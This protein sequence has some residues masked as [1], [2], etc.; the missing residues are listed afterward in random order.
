MVIV[1]ESPAHRDLL[2]ASDS[3]YSPW[4]STGRF[5][6]PLLLLGPQ[7]Y[8][9]IQRPTM[10][11]K[12]VATQLCRWFFALPLLVIRRCFPTSH[13]HDSQPQKLLTPTFILAWLVNF[14]QFLTFYVLIT[15]MALYAI[16]QFRASETMGGL[17]S[18]SFIIGATVARC[19]AGFV[20]DKVGKRKTLL[21]SLAVIVV[22]S[23]AYLLATSLGPLLAVRLI[24]GVGYAFA[25]TAV[26][27][28]AQ[29]AIPPHRRAEGTGYFALGPTLSTAAGPAL[30]VALSASFGYTAMFVTSACFA[31][32]G[33][34]IA[35][36]L[37]FPPEHQP[38]KTRFSLATIVHP[39]VIP[40]GCF[41][42]LIG[43]AY[44][45]VITYLN[46][47]AAHSGLQTG[48]SFFFIA[49]AAAMLIMRFFLGRL[50]DR[51]GDNVVIAL[52]VVSFI[53]AL[54]F[55]ATANATWHVIVAGAFTG[56][57][58]GTLMPACQ[59]I[60]VRLVPLQQIGVGIS[61]MF[62]LLDFGVGFG[63][64]VL[65]LVATS[66]GYSTMYM[67]MAG[68]VAMSGVVYILVHGRKPMAGSQPLA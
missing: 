29:A 25:S 2:N 52:G 46:A 55:L 18:S 47:Y 56:L 39:A 5:K 15:T 11:L 27:A 8:V 24:H 66:L 4:L 41:M 14:T 34:V 49:Y 65:G 58:F 12:P 36:F 1:S 23:F 60:S 31:V 37:P 6:G 57:G 7:A 43:V 62:L 35:L 68:L 21:A 64:I 50:Q 3:F 61:T 9:C 28:V 19:F 45:S 16:S 26:M 17:A 48:A 30:G 32:A 20:V 67:L 54:V 38:H 59:A 13:A 33:M 10:T 63:P 44:A 22:A 42:L 40:I 53:I 51:K